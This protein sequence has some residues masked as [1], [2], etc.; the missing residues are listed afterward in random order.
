MWSSRFPPSCFNCK[1]I[2]LGKGSFKY[3]AVLIEGQDAVLLTVAYRPPKCTQSAF[4][5]ELSEIL[6]VRITHHCRI[7]LIG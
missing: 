1:T 6:S 7:L 4:L 2:S 3:L 5:P